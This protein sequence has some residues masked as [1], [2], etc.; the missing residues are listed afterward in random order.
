[1]RSLKPSLQQPNVKSCF[2]ASSASYRKYFGSHAAA[3]KAAGLEPL[4][5]MKKRKR[6]LKKALLDERL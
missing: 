5:K 3:L 4:R 1:M 6:S 2:L